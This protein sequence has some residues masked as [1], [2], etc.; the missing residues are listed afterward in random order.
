MARRAVV[1][2]SNGP[3]GAGVLRYARDDAKQIAAAL[4]HPRCGF[5]VTEHEGLEDPQAIERSIAEVAEL[6]AEG[7]TFAVFFS[8]H[9]FVEGASLWLMLDKTTV[10]RPL[11]TALH[12]D[13]I[14]RAMKFSPAQHKILILDCCH[15]GMVFSDSRFKSDVGTKME[16]IVGP[17]DQESTSFVA[18]VASDRLERAREF[19]TLR[20]SF[21]TKSVCEALGRSFD[22][23]D[24]D[25]D[26]A[27]DLGDLRG[28]LTDRARAHNKLNPDARVPV[29]F[30]FGRERGRL[31]FTREPK[32]WIVSEIK[33]D[34]GLDFV[35]L[36]FLSS[37]RSAWLLGKTPITNAQYLTF[38]AATGYREPVGEHF[39]EKGRNSVWK[40][41]FRPWTV[42]EFADPDNPVVCVDFSDAL[43][44]AEWAAQLDSRLSPQL[45]PT[46]VWDFAA[47]GTPRPSFDRRIWSQLKIHHHSPSPAAVTGDHG[48][49]NRYGAVDLF[50]NVWEWTLLGHQH[51]AQVSIVADGDDWRG[52]NQQIRGGSF[53]DD[54]S[55]VD[56]ILTVAAMKEGTGTRHSDLG[57]RIAGE[58]N[59]DELPADVGA[60]LAAATQMQRG[61][62]FQRLPRAA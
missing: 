50:G 14:V 61:R 17:S 26:G 47:F 40:G 60:L 54:L 8:G 18:L 36:P 25:R 4:R 58:I 11:T 56:P 13:S 49:I 53:L 20:G 48:R 37:R 9:A 38:V 24:K 32:D 44:F 29:P 10:E 16:D 46:D 27:I 51:Q 30:V 35:V 2:G 59:L 5:E 3:K 42:A 15:A 39:I 33:G 52:R 45:V 12:A 41:P 19:D 22:D 23:A 57:F 62:P 1:F 55:Q 6:S 34:Y 43:A 28:W 21:L 7:D 31:F